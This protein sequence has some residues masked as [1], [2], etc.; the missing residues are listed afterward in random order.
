MQCHDD[1]TVP[2]Q[3]ITHGSS[4]HPTLCSLSYWQ[5]R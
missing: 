5:R 2:F 1:R 3:F 4:C